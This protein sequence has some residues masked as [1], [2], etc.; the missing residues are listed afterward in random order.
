MLHSGA[1]ESLAIPIG[2][3][4]GP[5][6]SMAQYQTRK[7]LHL[8]NPNVLI[9]QGLSYYRGVIRLSLLALK[10]AEVDYALL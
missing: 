9:Q 10:S 7:Y 6:R 5:G 3:Y 1:A 8:P 4:T 2:Q